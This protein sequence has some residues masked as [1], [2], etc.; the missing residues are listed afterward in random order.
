MMLL[1][2]S[3]LDH[4]EFYPSLFWVSDCE[5]FTLILVY[6]WSIREN[7]WHVLEPYPV[8]GHF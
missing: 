4:P 2:L 6:F 3:S 5:L 1:S 8:N 7:F